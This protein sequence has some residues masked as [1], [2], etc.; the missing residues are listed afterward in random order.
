MVTIFGH[1]Y[2]HLI[3]LRSIGNP[4]YAYLVQAEEGYCIRVESEDEV[5]YKMVTT[6]YE[7]E[8][9]HTITVIPESE[10]PDGE[11]INGSITPDIET[12]TE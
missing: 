1:T 8:G 3:I 5:I 6:V 12:V 4:I 10:V 2:E 11:E 9:T 7:R